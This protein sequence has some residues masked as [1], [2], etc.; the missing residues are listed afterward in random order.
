M[1]PTP[2]TCRAALDNINRQHGFETEGDVKL[3]AAC[4]RHRLAKFLLRFNAGRAIVPAH[5]AL[6]LSAAAEKGDP[7]WYLR[8]I[9]IPAGSFEFA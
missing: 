4:Q 6:G 2:C 7:S 3:V 9:S 1:K 5:D 8:D